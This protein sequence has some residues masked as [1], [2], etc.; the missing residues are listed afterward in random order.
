MRGREED[1]VHDVVEK[2][3]ALDLPSVIM[4]R[5]PMTSLVCS[6]MVAVRRGKE[7]WPKRGLGSRYKSTARERDGKIEGRKSRALLDHLRVAT[8]VRADQ[9]FEASV[10]LAWK[11]VLVMH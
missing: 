4:Y 9:H 5:A 6:G 1:P 11:M 7:F 10:G 8:V 2:K 3:T